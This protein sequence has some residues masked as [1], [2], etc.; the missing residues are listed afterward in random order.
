MIR[1]TARQKHIRMTPRKLRLVAS[2]VKKLSPVKAIDYLELINKRAALPI[3][4]T[5]KQAIANAEN[6]SKLDKQ[7]LKFF[8]IDIQEG[9]VYKRWRPVSR[10]RA[11]SILKRT[12][13]IKIVLEAEEKQEKEKATKMKKDAKPDLKDKKIK[14]NKG[15][16]SGTKS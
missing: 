2:A 11:H 1:V 9:P 10:G 3:A 14:T 6:N 13:H 8:Q 16:K 12:S 5:I 15:R 4:K 7:D